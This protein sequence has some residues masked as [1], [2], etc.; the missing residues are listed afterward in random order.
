MPYGGSHGEGATRFYWTLT[1]CSNK[2]VLVILDQ[3]TKS[4]EC[5]ALP[6]QTAEV[7]AT[8]AVND[9]FSCFGCHLQIF[10]DKGRYFESFSVLSS[11]SFRF[12]RLARWPGGEVH[13][14]LMT[15]VQ[16]VNKAITAGMNTW[17]KLPELCGRPIYLLG[18]T[19]N[20]LMQLTSS[21]LPQFGGL[22]GRGGLRGGP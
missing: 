3:F 14:T 16:Y 12:R 9:F 18:F 1:P 15:A 8:A 13:R 7:T 2:N 20:K 4:V 21:T 22:P 10:T 5:I 11:S 19:T 6:S 17:R